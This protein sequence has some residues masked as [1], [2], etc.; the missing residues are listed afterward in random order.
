MTI[1][2]FSSFISTVLCSAH[3]LLNLCLK[4][5]FPFQPFLAVIQ[6]MNMYYCITVLAHPHSAFHCLKL[7]KLNFAI[8][9]F[10]F[11]K[12]SWGIVKWLCIILHYIIVHVKT[13]QLE[14]SLKIQ[15]TQWFSNQC[16]IKLP[17]VFLF[18]NPTIIRHLY[19]YAPKNPKFHNHC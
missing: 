7:T 2:E 6:E 1:T 15:F 14:N 4:L 3:L 13:E 17:L 11:L 16:G 5:T 9:W 19:C 12:K 10:C 18:S 8:L